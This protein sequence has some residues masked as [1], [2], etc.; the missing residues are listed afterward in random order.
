MRV[1]LKPKSSIP[2]HDRS[3]N[4]SSAIPTGVH[5][6]DRKYAIGRMGSQDFRDIVDNR[7]LAARNLQLHRS[8]ALHV[9]IK[10]SKT[11]FILPKGATE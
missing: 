11:T 6:L 4:R 8:A 2:L 5:H 1:L 3:D 10:P 9:G 7:E